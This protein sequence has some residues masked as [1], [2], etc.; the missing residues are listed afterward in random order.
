MEKKMGVASVPK[1]R[2]NVHVIHINASLCLILCEFLCYEI[3]RVC[4][5]ALVVTKD[6]EP[7]ACA[8]CDGY[9]IREP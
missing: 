3:V 8:C 4:Y 1:R 5:A 9:S 2:L 6:K 7:I